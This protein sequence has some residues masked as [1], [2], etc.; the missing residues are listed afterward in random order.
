MPDDVPNIPGDLDLP[1]S[2]GFTMRGWDFSAAEV[3]DAIRGHRMLNPAFELGGNVCPWNCDFC[4]TESPANRGDRKR[5]LAGELSLERRLRLIDEA[6]GLG[7]RSINFVGAGEPTIDPDFWTLIERMQRCGITPIVYSEAS[8]KLG[9]HSFSQRLFDLGATVVVKVNS[10]TN[11]QYQDRVVRGIRS[12]PGIPTNSYT[13]QRARALDTLMDVGFNLPTPTRLAFDTII[14]RENLDDI[15]EIHRFGRLNNIFTIMVNYLPSG[16]TVDGHTS[17]ISWDE[18]HAMFRRLAAIDASDFGLHHAA[19]FPYSGGVPCTIRGLGLY[20]K[21]RGEVF[22]CPGEA[23]PL[24]NVRDDSLEAIWAKTKEIT[25]GFDGG[26]F[27]RQQ[28][29]KRMAALAKA[30][31]NHKQSPHTTL[32]DVITPPLPE[33]SLRV[34]KSV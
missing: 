27:P 11:A 9:S 23:I 12:K 24:G 2:Y 19:H 16:R 25:A 31:A 8:L 34:T 1:A 15:V 33:T 14:C 17:A 7:A 13:V 6:A 26:C 10:L 18:Q 30:Q 4:F 29:W 32:N 22:D 20:V 28:F 3:G 21:V 5:H